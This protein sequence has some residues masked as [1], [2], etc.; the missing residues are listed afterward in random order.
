M[1]GGLLLLHMLCVLVGSMTL[2]G[3]CWLLRDNKVVQYSIPYVVCTWAEDGRPAD[4]LIAQPNVP[5]SRQGKHCSLGIT[6]G[7][8]AEVFNMASSL[9]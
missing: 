7:H 5:A 8:T 3:L 4:L 6:A 1:A 9:I 2:W